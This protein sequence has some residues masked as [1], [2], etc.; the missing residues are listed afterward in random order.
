MKS[1]L[2]RIFGDLAV[3]NAISGTLLVLYATA[4]LIH[5]QAAAPMVV[6]FPWTPESWPAA[7]VGLGIGVTAL[8]AALGRWR[9]ASWATRALSVVEWLWI[10]VALQI[11]GYLIHTMVGVYEETR[12]WSQWS[13]VIVPGFT[14]LT[15]VV[16]RFIWQRLRTL[17]R[18]RSEAVALDRE[19]A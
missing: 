8:V 9:R 5:G 17:A 14:I 12:L 2:G 19:V 13:F 7:L 4:G 11:E 10:L 16:A 3:V 6:L 1:L 15:L 18:L